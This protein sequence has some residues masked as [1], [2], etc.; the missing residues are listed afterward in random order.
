MPNR[1][2]SKPYY[3]MTT[4][5][6][7]QA[8]T[9]FDREFVADTFG[10]PNA[11]QRAQLARARAKRGRPRVGAGSRT[12]CITVE[13]GLLAQADRLAKKLRLPR[14][15]LVARGLQAVVGEEVAM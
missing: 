10:P 4:E 11:R 3:E 5:E 15:A 7:R 13:K 1:K 6:L 14:A 9:E 8:T 12:I 2:R